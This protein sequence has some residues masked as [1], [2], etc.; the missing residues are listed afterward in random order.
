VAQVIGQSDADQNAIV[1]LRLAS[2]AYCQDLST[3][4]EAF[5]PGW[6]LA[7]QAT[8]SIEGNLAYIAY[9]GSSQYVVAIRGSLLDF[10]LGAFYDWFQQDFDVFEQVTWQFPP[11]SA[12]AAEYSKISQGAS[13]GLQHLTELV[14]SSG[15]SMLDFLL[16]QAIPSGASIGVV[17]HSLG[18]NLSTVFAPWLYYQITTVA[19]RSPP[20]L[21]PVFTFAAPTAGN[22]QF[23]TAFD[24]LF[25][26]S[27]RYF[28]ALDLVPMASVPLTILGIAL[29]Y[30]SPAPQASDVTVTYDNKTVSLADAFGMIAVAVK[31]AESFEGFGLFDPSDYSQTNVTRGAIM[32][33]QD[34]VLG[35]V[36]MTDP[37]DEQWFDQAEYQHSHTTYQSL[38]GDTT[39]VVCQES[40]EARA[41]SVV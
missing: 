37:V 16:S 32:L 9:N 7:W 13:D 19:K 25:P 40:S 30:P 1:A 17:G 10:T 5:A 23:A 15:V 18:G 24:N 26:N 31:A 33:N 14:D 29:L 27:W 36:K 2:I 8:E 28:N 20:S 4:L 11:P 35:P 6:S 41:G 22:V 39:P 3:A 34:L 38:L 21:F 12:G